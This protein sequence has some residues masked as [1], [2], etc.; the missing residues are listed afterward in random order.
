MRRQD[1]RHLPITPSSAVGS[2][3]LTG[4]SSDRNKGRYPFVCPCVPNSPT[5]AMRPALGPILILLPAGLLA[6][7]RVEW[8]QSIDETNA[9]VGMKLWV[10]HQDGKH[11]QIM[12]ADDQKLLRGRIRDDQSLGPCENKTKPDM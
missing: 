5:A 3:A 8:E 9:R 1:G 11:L 7:W 6:V 2:A 4:P 10:G 12:S